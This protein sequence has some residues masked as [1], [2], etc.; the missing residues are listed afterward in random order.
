MRG[1]EQEKREM[2]GKGGRRE[3]GDERKRRMKGRG[4]REMRG[5]AGRR[6]EGGGR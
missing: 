1:K 6:E 2:R 3:E 5:K 4:R